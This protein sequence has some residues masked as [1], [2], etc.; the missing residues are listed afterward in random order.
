MARAL[1]FDPGRIN[2]SVK[3][4]Y[5]TGLFQ[6]VAI[7]R[8]GNDLNVTVV[9]N[10]TVD[11]VL[12]SGNK[13]LATKDATAAISLKPRS[14]FTAAAAEAD[15][16]ALL[17]LYAKKGRFNATVTPNIIRLPDNRVNVVFQCTDGT[18][19]LVSRITFI[20]NA[21]FSQ[22][23]LRDVISHQTGRL[24]PVVVQQRSVQ[25]GTGGV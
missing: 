7:T 9:E 17:D 18:Q 2:D 21:H 16:R 10:P 24:V 14:V 6:D 19:T 5:A 8:V 11:Q 15:R 1:P 25:R 12:F 23:D 20:G 22:A 13:T 4:L 3:T